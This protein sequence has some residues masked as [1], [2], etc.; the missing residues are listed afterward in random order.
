MKYTELGLVNTK[1]LFADALANNYAI[2]AF[3]IYN[4]ETLTAVIDAG[5]IAHSP[6]IIAV[7]ESALKYMGSDMLIG[8]IH[9]AKISPDEGFALHLD[10]GKNFDICKH[11]IELGFSSV[12][13]DASQFD[14]QKNIEITKQVVNIAHKHNVSVEAELGTLAGIEDETTFGTTSSYTNPDD[15]ETFVNAT[16]IDSLAIAIGT[17]H[18]AYK[19]QNDNAELQFDILSKIANR[20]PKLP[21][22]LHGA[23]SIPQELITTINQFGGQ[24]SGARGIN[25]KQLQRAT[26]MNICKINVD[27]DLRLAFTAAVRE[28]LATNQNN[29]NPRDFLSAAREKMTQLCLDEIKFIMGSDNKNKT[30]PV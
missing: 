2:P 14:T 21:L 4:M 12:M 18:G 16:N 28:S 27:S 5:R 30:M 11:A 6:I 22:V 10:H 20:M 29:F 8:M 19:H 17:S 3:N 23:S 13:I 24:I 9:G 1:K 26:Q 25:N 7:S 15:V